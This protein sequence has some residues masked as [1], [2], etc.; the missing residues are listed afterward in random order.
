MLNPGSPEALAKG[1][2]CPVIDNGRGRGIFYG[3]AYQ[4]VTN[5]DCPMHGKGRLQKNE[6]NAPLSKTTASKPLSAPIE[7]DLEK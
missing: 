3:G 7:G 4:L 6:T 1:C 5:G 2:R